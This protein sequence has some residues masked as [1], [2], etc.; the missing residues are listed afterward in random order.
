[1]SHPPSLTC[2]AV[3][4]AQAVYIILRLLQELNV[5]AAAVSALPAPGGTVNVGP[6]P[7]AGLATRAK[8]LSAALKA[9]LLLGDQVDTPI[10]IG[11]AA[12]TPCW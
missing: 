3:L 1:M 6:A 10:P 9:L 5:S 11:G 4:E 2:R 8:L 7:V 12:V